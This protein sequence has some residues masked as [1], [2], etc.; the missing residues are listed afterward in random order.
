MSETPFRRKL[1]ELDVFRELA[2]FLLPYLAVCHIVVIPIMIMNMME[3]MLVTMSAE[4]L[5]CVIFPP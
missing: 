5:A 1:W 4:S 2:P 3:M